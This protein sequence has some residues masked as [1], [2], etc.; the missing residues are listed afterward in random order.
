MLPRILAVTV[1]GLLLAA[2]AA[3]LAQARWR[4]VDTPNFVVIGDVSA[5]DLR[6]IGGKFESF[7]DA[8]GRIL[9]ERLI[10]TVVP[11]VI[12]VFSTD[13]VYKPFKPKYEGRP[14]EVGG[15]FM[16]GRDI[17]Y[18]TIGD[19]ENLETLFHEYTHLLVGNTGLTMPLWLGEGFAEYYST[20]EFQRSGREVQVG[21]LIGEHLA[22]LNDTTFIPLEQFLQLTHD[23]PL[24]NEGSR[25]S[26]LYA[27][28]WALTHM[29]HLGE[30]N[31]RT[32][33]S[34][35]LQ[36]VT[37]GM[38]SLEAWK[39]AFGG[40]DVM[41]ELQQYIRRQ[42]FTAHKYR[43]DEKA[44]TV[45]KLPVTEI[46]RSDADAYLAQILMRLREPEPAAARLAAARQR[47]AANSSV[48]VSEAMLA[49]A[50]DDHALAAQRLDGLDVGGDWLLSYQ[51]GALLAD[52]M[53]R[54][55]SALTEANL[56]VVRAHFAASA[57]SRPMM[58]HA[59]Y[60]LASLELRRGTVGTDARA[61]L[62]H[63]RKQTPGRYEYHLIYAQILG[64]AR[65]FA[66]AREVLGPLLN[67]RTP[68]HVREVARRLM[69]V[70][71]DAEI[72]KPLAEVPLETVASTVASTAAATE[73]TEREPVVRPVYRDTKAG[74]TRLEGVLESI[75]CVTGKGITFHVSAGGNVERFIVPAF[76]GI[77]FITYRK[78]L[79]GNIGCGPLKPAMAVYLTWR[80]GSTP[81]ARV[82]VAIEFLPAK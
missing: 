68:P 17:N 64:R 21:G 61:A 69:G 24:Y 56:A 65:E 42:L 67:P 58:P 45:E 9:N 37:S 43:M 44:A 76:D 4:R 47:E 52:V 77:E 29:L 75:E 71:A 54:Q 2:T 14:K 22:V 57:R 11:A 73:T 63:A 18:I 82:P 5:G 59:A 48:R 51:A 12:V 25:R 50:R 70:I 36:H 10:A 38:S 41:K 30:P 66:A 33:L 31:R 78:D 6:D 20:L 23:S 35:Y 7:R 60:R 34:A 46:S 81:G 16:P 13:D 3:P 39:Q 28:A 8:L 72:G 27:Q 49:V 53:E 26:V 80:A 40:F 62:D 19:R 32:E 1:V 79:A 74:E 55:P 15:V